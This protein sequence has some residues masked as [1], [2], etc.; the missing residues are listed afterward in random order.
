MA[1]SKFRAPSLYLKGTKVAYINKTSTEITSNDEAQFG[2]AV[3]MG[4]SDGIPVTKITADAI[5]PY[6]GTPISV[7]QMM[8]AKEYVSV[9]LGIMDGKI[10][11][12]E[13][14]ITSVKYDGDNQKGVLTG[15]FTFEGGQPTLT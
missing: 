9:A 8:L 4:Y 15:Q 10:L 7:L 3:V 6:G 13:M 12:L 5:V 14:R 1:F 2:D 11:S